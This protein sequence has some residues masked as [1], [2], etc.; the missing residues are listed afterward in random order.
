MLIVCEQCG[1]RRPRGYARCAVC[2]APGKAR[3]SSKSREQL[4]RLLLRATKKLHSL[5]KYNVGEFGA[6]LGLPAV[7]PCTEVPDGQLRRYIRK[8]C[9]PRYLGPRPKGAL[10]LHRCDKPLCVEPSHLFYGSQR[11]NMRDCVLKGRK[12]KSLKDHGERI[13]RQHR[14]VERLTAQ[15]AALGVEEHPLVA[16]ARSLGAMERLFN[17]LSPET[18]VCNGSE[19]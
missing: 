5:E 11:D 15:I 1:S 13:A 12:P 6:E 7:G 4:E 8:N 16:L 14:K 19:A 18:E 10:L 17:L 3:R 2:S 9:T